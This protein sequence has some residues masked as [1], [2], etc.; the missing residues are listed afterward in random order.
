[1]EVIDTTIDYVIQQGSKEGHTVGL[2][3]GRF[4][5][6]GE[7]FTPLDVPG[8][9]GTEPL[10]INDQ[11]E[12]VGSAD[13]QSFVYAG[14]VFSLIAYPQATL[15]E[16]FGNNNQGQLVGRYID[17]SG[18]DHGFIATPVRARGDQ[19]QVAAHEALTL[20]AGGHHQAIGAPFYQEQCTPGSRQWRCRY[21]AK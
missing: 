8:A 20:S 11:G 18:V 9:L 12:I 15:T 3:N 7:V 16:V 10:G 5:K 4:L 1:L 19:R 6:D 2:F 21:G 14:G 17:S 13:A